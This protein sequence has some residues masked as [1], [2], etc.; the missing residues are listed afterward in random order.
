[1][2]KKNL[3]K[4]FQINAV[5][6]GSWITIGN[7][8]VAEIMANA[9][10]DWLA[11]DLE[12]GAISISEAADIIRVIELCGVAPLVRLTSNNS[13]QIKRVMDAGAHGVIVPMV[14]TKLDAMNAVASVK[15]P[16]LGIRGV[17]LARAQ[18]YGANF[19]E[20]L[21]WQATQAVIIVMIE[22][23]DAIANLKEILAVPGVD[24]FFIGPF[25][26]SCSLGIPGKFDDPKFIEAMNDIQNIGF[27]SGSVPGLHIVEPN[28]NELNNRVQEGYRFIA[29]SVDSRI[30][31]V[32][33]RQGVNFVKDVGV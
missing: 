22:H 20:Y 23:I 10:F 29:Y 1:M 14:N 9:G 5:T 21:E 25:D 4:I 3:K 7:V 30:L 18:G 12:H 31:D 24:G 16:P 8:A 2:T 19:K 33:V 6:L 27:H 15:Y 17:G 13:N 11:V 26:L 28:L 32:G